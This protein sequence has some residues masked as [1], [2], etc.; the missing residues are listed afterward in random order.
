MAHDVSHLRFFCHYDSNMYQ[1]IIMTAFVQTSH[2]QMISTMPMFASCMEA[3]ITSSSSAFK[4]RR[5]PLELCSN[6]CSMHDHTLIELTDVVHHVPERRLCL[7]CLLLLLHQACLL[8]VLADEYRADDPATIEANSDAKAGSLAYNLLMWGSISAAFLLSGYLYLNDYPHWQ[9]SLI[10][11]GTA[12]ANWK[13]FDGTKQGAFLAALLTVGAPVTE[14]FIVN[15]LHL[16]HYDR[17]DFFGVPHWL[18]GAMHSMPQAQ[19]T[20]AATYG[21]S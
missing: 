2:C 20:L 7:P 6:I 12:F 10:L 14:T 3:S 13:A 15:G 8:Q 5:L 21:R 9:C 17:P 18:D 4:H 16:W 19:A 11:S 1:S